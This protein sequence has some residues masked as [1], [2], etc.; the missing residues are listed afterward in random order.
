MREVNYSLLRFSSVHTCERRTKEQNNKL[1]T[2]NPYKLIAVAFCH[3]QADKPRDP[4][5]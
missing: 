2:G 5:T 1:R 4:K 3:N